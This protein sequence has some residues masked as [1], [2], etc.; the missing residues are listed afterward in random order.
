MPRASSRVAAAER[1]ER[2]DVH[3][4]PRGSAPPQY[5]IWDGALGNWVDAAGNARPITS[6]KERRLEHQ[7]ER[8]RAAAVAFASERDRN[9]E[10]GR[11]YVGLTIQIPW[12]AWGSGYET[13][14]EY[15]TATVIEY[16]PETREGDSKK[17][18]SRFHVA[19]D[20]ELD[21]DDTHL[22]WDELLGKSP[23]RLGSRYAILDTQ[24]GKPL[25]R[26][27]PP[28]KPPR[29]LVYG[30]HLHWDMRR[31]GWYNRMGEHIEQGA[32]AQSNEYSNEL[33]DVSLFRI[34]RAFQRQD[35]ESDFAA[36]EKSWRRSHRSRRVQRLTAQEKRERCLLPAERAARGTARPRFLDRMP[37]RASAAPLTRSLGVF[38]TFTRALAM[39]LRHGAWEHEVLDV[40]RVCVCRVRR[41]LLPNV[42]CDARCLPE[43][44]I[45]TVCRSQ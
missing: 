1:A 16:K 19:F 5:P 24:P 41:S 20:P 43:I 27:Q 15:S 2:G 4:R 14:A 35:S 25:G 22:S 23:C 42:W 6:R 44:P 26:R 39:L 12:T 33:D 31:E 37:S 36:F 10:R 17:I 21:Y 32:R 40:R 45:G 38:E 30:G 9:A 7:K 18:V 28:G 11:E 13:S 34:E 8:R 29:D 3:P